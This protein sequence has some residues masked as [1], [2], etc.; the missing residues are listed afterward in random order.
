MAE[1]PDNQAKAPHAGIRQD[2][3]DAAFLGRVEQL[4]LLARRMAT[5]GA[6]A[7]RR[8]RIVGSGIEFA[9][10]RGY[11]PGDDLRSV[12]WKLYARTERL[13]LRL[14]EEEEDLSVYF[15]VD[16]STSMLMAPDGERTQFERALQVSAALA[17]IALSNLDRVAVVPFGADLG[18]PMR[19]VRG[20]NQFFQVLR[21][22]S[23]IQPGGGT[24]ITA[25]LGQWLRTQPRPG[26]AVVISDFFDAKGLG[27]ALRL[28]AYRGFEPMVLH[29]V[30]RSLLD[31][32]A[33]GD[34]AMVDVE[35][36][37]VREIVLT[38]ELLAR[39]RV[40]FEA[41]GHDVEKAARAASARSLQVDLSVPFD[42]IVM[43]VF[44]AGG[45]LG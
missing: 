33:Q 32:D 20:K 28:L 45:F 34:L 17:Y 12:D 42:D 39:Y 14:Y 9:D 7:N 18:E 5:S 1:N 41:L 27:D 16:R 22:L 30:D 43:R 24:D 6:R 37:E 23:A 2:L 8:S 21:A 40:A 26:L 25:S 19:A 38:P 44:R 13:N 3:F 36:G 11:T 31:A 15:L 35:T 29:L 10:H 4:A